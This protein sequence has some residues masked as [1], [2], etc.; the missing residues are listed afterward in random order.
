MRGNLYFSHN[1][2]AL[3]VPTSTPALPETTIMAASAA[4]AASSTSPEKSK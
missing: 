3:S 2:H 4:L 1:S